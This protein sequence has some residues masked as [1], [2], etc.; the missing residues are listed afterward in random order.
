M[1][2]T[3]IKVV[4]QKDV[5]TLGTGG[6][7]VRVRPGYARNYLIPRGLAVPATAA[8][9]LRVD[10]LKKAA[11]AH[12]QK[13]LTDAKEQQRKIESVA[14]KIERS[15][16][17]EGKMYGSVTARDIE[18]A[19]AAVGVTID[20]K[21]LLLPEPLKTLGLSEVQIKLHPEVTAKLRV[22]VVKKA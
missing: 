15:V 9:L 11:L 18:L 10:E 3:P 14:V 21:R 20:R 1:M 16:G 7:V 4:L 22:E 17:D 2:A 6:D 13:T 12:A 19:F 8:N 5:D